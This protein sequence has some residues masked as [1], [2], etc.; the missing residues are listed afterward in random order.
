LC[1]VESEGAT[2]CPGADNDRVVLSG[3]AI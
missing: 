2:A 3:H 1:Q